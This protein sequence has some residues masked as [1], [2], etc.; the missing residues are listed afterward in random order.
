MTEPI[1]VFSYFLP[2]SFHCSIIRTAKPVIF[3]IYFLP[4]SSHHTITSKPI[5]FSI[6]FLP[7][8]FLCPVISCP[9]I[10]PSAIYFCPASI[11]IST[12][13][14]V[15]L[16]SINGFPLIFG[17]AVIILLPQITIFVLLPPCCL[18]CCR[19]H[20]KCK[21]CSTSYNCYFFDKHFHCFRF[22]FFPHLLCPSFS[23]CIYCIY[24]HFIFLFS[25]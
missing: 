15:I 9:Q 13:I 6:H 22:F 8:S 25:S 18:N 7:V 10:I 3:S 4:S 1:V 23:Y 17:I 12:G 20:R 21:R 24:S 11:H 19:Y 14:K 5:V 16:F 2:A